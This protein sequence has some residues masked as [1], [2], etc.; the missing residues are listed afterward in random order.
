VCSLWHIAPTKIKERIQNESAGTKPDLSQAILAGKACRSMDCASACQH[1]RSCCG[2]STGFGW[3]S[4]RLEHQQ[5]VLL[6]L[7]P[8]KDTMKIIPANGVTGHLLRSGYDVVFRVYDGT[9]FIDYDLT[10]SDLCVTI[11]DE[12][13]AFYS[14]P[15]SDRLDH[16][17]ETLGISNA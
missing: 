6:L 5:A 4:R 10:H 12:D 17:P 13:A 14:E 9:T 2:Q 8:T 7:L 1:N 11:T 3:Y 15:R 16:R